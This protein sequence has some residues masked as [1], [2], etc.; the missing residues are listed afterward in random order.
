MPS[1]PTVWHTPAA[2][3]GAQAPA[4]SMN[5]GMYQQQYVLQ[6][7]SWEQF[8]LYQTQLA[9]W[10]AQYGEQVSFILFNK[11]ENV[12]F[13]INNIIIFTVSTNAKPDFEYTK[14]GS[15]WICSAATIARLSTTS[16][17]ATSTNN[18][19]TGNVSTTRNASSNT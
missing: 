3:A 9:Q 11:C 2:Q 10:Q 5:M 18:A 15:E 17:T 7:Q 6:Q 16:T 14:Y 4:M 8:Q 19:A 12:D 13:K 1:V